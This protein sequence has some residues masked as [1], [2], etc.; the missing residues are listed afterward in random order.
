M[1]CGERA[2]GQERPNLDAAVPQPAEESE[3]VQRPQLPQLQIQQR[4]SEARRRL[5]HLAGGTRHGGR[6][7]P[8]VE[9][10]HER[11]QA[12]LR[13]AQFCRVVQV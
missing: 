13:A 9:R 6:E 3:R 10:P 2:A 11:E 1:D 4:D 8:A 7:P 12:E 5:R